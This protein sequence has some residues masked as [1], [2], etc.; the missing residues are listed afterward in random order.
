MLIKFIYFCYPVLRIRDLALECAAAPELPLSTLVLVQAFDRTL[1]AAA[2]TRIPLE[3][4]AA[5]IDYQIRT[6]RSGIRALRQLG[7]TVDERNL[8]KGFPGLFLGEGLHKR[9]LQCFLEMAM[10]LEDSQFVIKTEACC[11]V[12]ATISLDDMAMAKKVRI[13]QG[14]V[15]GIRDNNGK[16]VKLQDL[17]EYHATNGS[18]DSKYLTHVQYVKSFFAVVALLPDGQ[19][20]APIYHLFAAQDWN[21]QDFHTVMTDVTSTS[22]VCVGCI[23]SDTNCDI[24]AA[25]PSGCSCAICMITLFFSNSPRQQ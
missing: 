18:F 13:L 23:K 5:L 19:L 22:S 16:R 6:G 3:L 7:I 20:T 2:S 9:S 11:L 4:K 15:F 17:A 25:C 14:D 21:A 24:L 8:R 1:S 10:C 12:M